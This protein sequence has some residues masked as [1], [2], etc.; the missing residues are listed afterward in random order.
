MVG[1]VENVSDG[2]R[3]EGVDGLRVVADDRDVGVGSAHLP[4]DVELRDVGVLVLVD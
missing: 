4:Q 1:E 2:C 3:P